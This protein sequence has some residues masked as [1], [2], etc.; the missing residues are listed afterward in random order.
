M[1]I[2]RLTIKDFLQQSKDRLVLDVRSPGEYNHAHIPFATSFPLF[3]DEERKIVGTTY[4]QKSRE[5]AIKIGLDFFGPK[6]RK[7]VEEAE[8]ISNSS[9]SEIR[10]VKP[11]IFIYC[12][13]GGMRS[14]AIAWLLDLYGFK[15]YTLAGGYKVFRNYVLQT[16]EQPFQF[17]IL[18]GYTGSGKTRVLNELERQTETVIDL[19]RIASHKG[20][21]FGSFKMPPQPKQEMFENLLATELWKKSPS[22]THPSPIWLEDESQRIGDLNIPN[23]LWNTMRRSPILFLE[24]PFEERLNYIVEEYGECEKEKLIDATTRISQRL[25]GLDAKNTIGFLENGELKEAFRILLRYYDKHYLKGLHNR[26]AVSS[27]LTKID[28]ETV[29]ANNAVLLTKYQPA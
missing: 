12:W 29:A 20:S 8:A 25:G 15:V 19:E 5:D 7:M 21:A 4:K 2:Q 13:R 9:Q 6:M 14:A 23:A 27:L 17:K 16:F 28:C 22:I 24:I 11:E 10:N 1:A 18:G 26:K 3:T